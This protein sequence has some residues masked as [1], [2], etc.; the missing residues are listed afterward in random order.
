MRFEVVEAEQR[1]DE[2]K[3]ARAGRATGSRASD[4][5]AKIKT[6][7]AAA[8]RDYRMQLAIERITGQPIE[9][10]ISR[11]RDVQRGVET[12]APALGMYEA[13]SGNI[14][15]RTGFLKML[16]VMSGCSLDADIDDFKTLVEAKCPK[17]AIHV[18]YIRSRV[19]P[20]DYRFQVIHNL[21]VTGAEA[22]DFVSYN[23]QMP[24]GLQ[25]LCLRFER[26]DAAIAAY[27]GELNKFLNEVEE[28]V[29]ELLRLR[30]A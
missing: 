24:E 14:I 5:M 3:S 20:R 7:E 10:D 1:S 29:G 25:Y 15:R 18:E 21:W 11:F 16:D 9:D 17:P 22:C 27:E 6:G 13:Y 23:A 8:R 26:D 19:I 30:A 12:E 2:W 28:M 4:V